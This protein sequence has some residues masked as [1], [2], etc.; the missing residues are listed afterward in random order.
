MPGSTL[1][2]IRN[3][4]QGDYEYELELYPTDLENAIPTKSGTGQ[5]SI[6]LI[7][8]VLSSSEEQY[9]IEAV[10]E[11]VSILKSISWGN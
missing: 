9:D 6:S 3:V 4:I 5:Y 1:H 10:K 11:M 7:F 2:L 8:P